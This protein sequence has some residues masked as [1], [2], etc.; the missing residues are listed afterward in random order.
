MQDFSF[1]VQMTESTVH[2]GE[3]IKRSHTLN[4]KGKIANINEMEEF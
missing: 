2:I 3:K 4:N 1:L